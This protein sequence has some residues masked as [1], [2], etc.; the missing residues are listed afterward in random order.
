M[1]QD[2]MSREH[3]RLKINIK[4]SLA[5]YGKHVKEKQTPFELISSGGLSLNSN[6]NV[7]THDNTLS[8]LQQRRTH[9]VFKDTLSTDHTT[10]NNTSAPAENSRFVSCGYTAS[11]ATTLLVNNA[12]FTSSYQLHPAVHH[13]NRF[14]TFLCRTASTDCI[15]IGQNNSFPIT[16]S[17]FSKIPNTS[18][19]HLLLYTMSQCLLDFKNPNPN[20]MRTILMVIQSA[21]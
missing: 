21:E 4:Q 9:F 2:I 18:V 17:S 13:S 14:S 7:E 20:C 3:S 16:Q 5:L 6:E 15:S 12:S 8:H 11:G 19:T 10:Q 1:K